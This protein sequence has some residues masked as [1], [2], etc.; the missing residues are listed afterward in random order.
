M[1]KKEKFI[2]RSAKV[3]DSKLL[4]NWVNEK[5]VRNNSLNSEIVKWDIHIDWF[6]K[7]MESVKCEIFI[8][9]NNK[10]SVGQVRIEEDETGFWLIDYSIDSAFR[11]KGYGYVMIEQLINKI[12]KCKFKA[13]V[14]TKNIASRRVFEKLN[15]ALKKINKV[16]EYTLVSK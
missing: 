8:L 16:I 6:C 4:F 14:K 11:G 2:L 5:E 13:V 12:P 9:E 3:S 15:F 7:K 1:T 10:V